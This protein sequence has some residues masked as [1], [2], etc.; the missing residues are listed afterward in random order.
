MHWRQQCSRQ[1][2]WR[3]PAIRIQLTGR[4]APETKTRQEQSGRP[5]LRCRTGKTGWRTYKSRICPKFVI[6]R[7]RRVAVFC[8]DCSRFTAQRQQERLYSLQNRDA[9]FCFEFLS[10]P[11]P[12]LFSVFLFFA[13]VDKRWDRKPVKLI[14]GWDAGFG[15]NRNYFTWLVLMWVSKK[16]DSTCVLMFVFTG[17]LLVLALVLTRFRL[18][19][20]S[21]VFYGCPGPIK[22][23]VGQDSGFFRFW[24]QFSHGQDH[25][26]MN[27]WA[28]ITPSPGRR[29]NWVNL[30][31][32]LAK[33]PLSDSLRYYCTHLRAFPSRP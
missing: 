7:P 9:L 4:Q 10:F 11:G 16:G 14:S 6:V 2:R 17:P 13:P 28:Q 31:L 27:T 22:V 1:W 24:F 30:A 15:R 8:F 26:R 12:K 32:A 19:L 21:R 29:K 23:Q 20:V 18:V 25:H 3:R 5:F 33:E